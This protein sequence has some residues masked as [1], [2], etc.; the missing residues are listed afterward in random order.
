MKIRELKGIGEKREKLLGA[1]GIETAEQLVFCFPAKYIEYKIPRSI[2]E[3]QNGDHVRLNCRVASGFSKFR[4]KSGTLVLGCNLEWGGRKVKAVWFHAAYAEKALQK[5]SEHTFSAEVKKEDDKLTLV[6]PC[7]T[8][9]GVL[10]SVV[11][12]YNLPD[13]I[14]QSAFSAV[15]KRALEKVRIAS[16]LVKEEIEDLNE[17]LYRIHFPETMRDV[18]RAKFRFS[19]EEAVQLMTAIRL[20]KSD[21]KGKREYRYS[22]DER[23]LEEF[24]TRLPFT[25]TQSQESA[26]QTLLKKLAGGIP[27]NC[28]LQGDVGSGKTAVA[29]AMMEYAV[30]N[31]FQTVMLAP[32]EVLAEQHFRAANRL[33]SG[34]CALLTGSIAKEQRAETLKRIASGEV[35]IIIGTHAA[36]QKSVK[37]HNLAL[38]VTDEQHR[39]GVRERA[40]LIEKGNMPDVLSMSATPIPRTLALILYGDM[41]IITIDQKP[42]GRKPVKTY[43]VPKEKHGDMLQYLKERILGG[44]QAFAVCPSVYEGTLHSVQE[45]YRKYRGI[46]GDAETAFMH[47]KMRGEEKQ[48]IM[49]DFNAGKIKVLVSTTVIE[50]G[51]DIRNADIMIIYDADRFGLSSLHQL[52]GR[53]GRGEKQAECFLFTETEN[54]ESIDRLKFFKSCNDG[55]HIA[56]VDMRLRGAGDYLGTRQSGFISRRT[57]FTPETVKVAAEYAEKLKISR[58]AFLSCA[59]REYAD[60]VNVVL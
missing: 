8:E 49:R 39:F 48:K 43:L 17:S 10:P 36:F 3:I 29:F 15:V 12:V 26:I 11:P 13:G 58:E 1:M 40:R 56:D 18:E 23:V 22:A 27:L 20:C 52:R 54:G 4:G 35:K 32:T 5:N 45:I 31:G 33:L 50:V 38:V 28:L 19:V 25:L 24:R 6:N 16:I 55:F 47:G 9:K 59:F 37:Y 60:L 46:T 7:Y 42:S 51:V 30:K 53:V 41:D 44:S 34:D 21:G 14:G 2:D 57:A